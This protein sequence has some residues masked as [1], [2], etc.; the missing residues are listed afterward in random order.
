[1][2]LALAQAG[3]PVEQVV[4]HLQQTRPPMDLTGLGLW[5]VQRQTRELGGRLVWTEDGGVFTLTVELPGD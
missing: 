3:V 4:G 2:R 1:M 5:S